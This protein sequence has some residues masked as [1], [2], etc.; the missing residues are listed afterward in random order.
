VEVQL[1][2]AVEVEREV[3]ALAGGRMIVGVRRELCKSWGRRGGCES[4]E[5]EGK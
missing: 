2:G 3:T 4:A 1:V 5:G